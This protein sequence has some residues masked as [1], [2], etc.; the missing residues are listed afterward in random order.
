[1]GKKEKEKD[2]E[3]DKSKKYNEIRAIVREEL[4]RAIQNLRVD[5]QVTLNPPIEEVPATDTPQEEVVDQQAPGESSTATPE[6]K[7]QEE[8]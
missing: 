8:A 4:E 5:V 7:P 6:T 3:K 2:K 1:M